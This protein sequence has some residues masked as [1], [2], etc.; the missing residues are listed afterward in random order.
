MLDLAK[1][2]AG[3]INLSI[4]AI[5]LPGLISESIQLISPLANT[6]GISI[7][8]GKFTEIMVHADRTRLKQVIINLI[9]NAVKY[10]REKGSI[11]IRTRS[12]TPG[13]IR[14]EIEDSG[15]GISEE[16]LQ[17]LFQPFNRLNAEFSE[18]EGTG[19][20]LAICKK[21]VDM[22]NGQ[23]GVTSKLGHGSCFWVELPICFNGEIS[24]DVIDDKEQTKTLHTASHQYTVLSIDDNPVNLRLLTQIFSRRPNYHLVTAHSSD[25]GIELALAYQPNLILLDINM[26]GMNGHEVL[27]ILKT[28]PTLK[29]TPIMAVTANALPSDIEKGLAAGFS[30]YQTKP[31]NIHSFLQAVD[32][33]IQQHETDKGN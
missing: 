24:S 21:L 9:S 28:Q 8:H 31:I 4:E 19:I 2:E 20:G 27:R 16:N 17:Y 14:I 26:P 5:S 23:I 32:R 22:M 1:I 30:D 33:L 29:S 12:Q 18:T 3:K 11:S 15:Q 13:T 7:S 25:L 10:N 6:K